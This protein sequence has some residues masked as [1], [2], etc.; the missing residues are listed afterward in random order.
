MM[1]HRTEDRRELITTSK[2]FHFIPEQLFS[3]FIEI[4]KIFLQKLIQENIF[5]IE[6]PM[7]ES[8]QIGLKINVQIAFFSPVTPAAG[9]SDAGEAGE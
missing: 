3:L 9:I 5:L 2:I 4:G 7:N 8:N 1:F 6:K